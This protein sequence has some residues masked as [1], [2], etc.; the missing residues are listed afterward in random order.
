MKKLLILLLAIFLSAG[1]LSAQEIKKLDV[2]KI[3]TTKEF[4]A[5]VKKQKKLIPKGEFET[6][7]EYKSKLPVNPDRLMT[8]VD[9]YDSKVT[10]PLNEKESKLNLEYD[11]EKELF[12]G[13][14]RRDSEPSLSILLGTK[15]AGSY[16]GSN[17][18]GASKI[19]SKVEMNW[20]DLVAADADYLVG[21]PR[22]SGW[23]GENEWSEGET[24]TIIKP[25]TDISLSFRVPRNIAKSL[26]MKWVVDARILGY[27]EQQYTQA[28]TF[29]SPLEVKQKY[30]RIYFDYV[31]AYLYLINMNNG[32]ILFTHALWVPG[33]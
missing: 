32:D 14:S 13:S 5:K 9:V 31:E 26:N 6:V 7:E 25:S 1:S 28:A 24:E 29:S 19:V 27:K 15:G 18:M 10:N 23:I 4:I 3:L 20:M 8:Y 21:E 17:A 2:S 11:P 12:E 22:W 30:I 33:W 16:A